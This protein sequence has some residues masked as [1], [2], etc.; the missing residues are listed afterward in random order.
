MIIMPW[1]K[2]VDWMWKHW[3]RFAQ[4]ITKHKT[5]PCCQRQMRDVMSRRRWSSYVDEN[6]NW[7]ESCG[8]CHKRDCDDFESL[9]EDYY[10]SR[11]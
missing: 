1:K 7:L 3:A 2:I 5:C 6:L 10:R 8:E 4:S 11:L 9:W